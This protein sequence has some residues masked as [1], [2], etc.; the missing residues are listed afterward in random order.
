MPSVFEKLSHGAPTFFVHKD[1]GVFATFTDNHHDD[2][3][4]ALW[5]PAPSGMQSVLIEE[6]PQTYFRPPYVGVSGWIGIELPEI[7][8]DALQIHVREAWELVAR[9]GKKRQ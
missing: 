8:D 6:A 9:K 5:V 3:H 7:G 1:K 4:L 2:G